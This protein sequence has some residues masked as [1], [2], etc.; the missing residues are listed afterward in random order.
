MSRKYRNK[1]MKVQNL[2]GATQVYDRIC[3]CCR[4]PFTSTFRKG[5]CPDCRLCQERDPHCD[6]ADPPDRSDL[7]GGLE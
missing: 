4:R 2:T 1:P 6:E 7:K 5:F 3:D